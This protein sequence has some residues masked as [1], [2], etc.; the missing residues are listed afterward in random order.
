MN[1]GDL[2]RSKRNG[3]LGTFVGYRMSGDYKYAEVMWIDH[4]SPH[5][6]L[7]PISTIQPSL[8]EHVSE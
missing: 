1:P 3:W 2:I 5:S 6:D 8:I 4:P 7:S